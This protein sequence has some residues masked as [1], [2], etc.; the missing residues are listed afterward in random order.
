[1]E[2][3][4]LPDDYESGVSSPFTPI[5]STDL[6]PIAVVAQCLDNQWIR[7][8]L[9]DEMLR[10]RRSFADKSVRVRRLQDARAEYMRA[11]LNAEQVVVN[12]SFFYNNPV[13]YQDFAPKSPAR[14]TFKNLLNTGVIVPFLLDEAA[15]GHPPKNFTVDDAGWA[16]WCRVLLETDPRV[17]R[18]SWDDVDNKQ[19]L[20][21]H[22]FTPFRRFLGSLG[23]FEA[24]GLA[25]DLQLDHDAAQGLLRR[26]KEVTTWAM[27]QQTITREDF[28]RQFVVT[29]GTRPASGAYDRD[30]PFAAELKQLVDLRYV[31]SLPDVIDR[32]PLTPV[33]SLH[34][35][36]LQEGREVQPSKQPTAPADLVERLLRRQAFDL[37]QRPLAVS[38]SGLDLDLI[39]RGRRTDEW[40]RYINA[41]QS[42]VRHPDEF[43]TRAQAVYNGYV[44]LAGRLAELVGR[45]RLSGGTWAPVIKVVIEVV[46]ATLSIV[47]GTDTL[48]Q[49]AGMVADKV[50]G[51]ASTAVVRVVVASHDRRRAQGELSTGIELM[52][53]KLARTKDDWQE[54]IRRLG[55]SGLPVQRVGETLNDAGIDGTD[56]TEN[57]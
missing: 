31:T 50:A 55:E 23:F 41:L 3:D 13:V 54:L 53:V 11:I 10:K 43:D 37:V 15:P 30:K 45:R 48:V 44:D 12:R 7:P 8:D 33:D 18:L 4:A 57:A 25:R 52:K 27:D 46:G 17:V 29:D 39:W 42:L 40:E 16:A 22:L 2:E 56:E 9:L 47:Y 6:Q 21:N 38:L 19:Y 5:I 35:S 36:A 1:L 28:Y 34:R 20:T 51:T 24:D 32:Y 14:E 26:L 49:V